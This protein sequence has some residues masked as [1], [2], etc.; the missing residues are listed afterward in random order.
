M[1]AADDELGIMSGKLGQKPLDDGDGRVIMVG[2]TEEK[3]VGG[4]I[5]LEEAPKVLLQ[6]LVDPLEGLEDRDRRG[7]V[8]KVPAPTRDPEQRRE[9]GERRGHRRCGNQTEEKVRIERDHF[10]PSLRLSP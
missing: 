2:N 1:R 7:K 10:L 8:G 3:L 4:V 5:E 9:R 6:P